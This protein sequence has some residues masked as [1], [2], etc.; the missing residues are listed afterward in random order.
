MALGPTPIPEVFVLWHPRCR[1]GEA[2]APRIHDWLR[3][4]NGQG[5]EVFYRSLAAPDAPEGGLPPAL[6]G[7][8]RGAEGS[9]GKPNVSNLQ[10]LLPLID[11]NLIVDPAWRYWLLELGKKNSG[12]PPRKILPVALDATAYNLPG[13]LR[14]LNFL[15]PS[16]LPMPAGAPF[17]GEAF[18]AV[19]RSLLRQ[20]TEA[21]CRV[22]LSRV[23]QQTPNSVALDEAA[24]K[25]TLFLSHA[26]VDGTVPAK[27]LRDHI[28]SQTQLAAFY[29]ENDIAYGSAFNRAIQGDVA[30]AETA[31]FIAVRSAEYARRAWCRRELSLFRRPRLVVPPV[32]GDGSPKPAE[33]WGMYPAIVVEA[34][35]A[36]KVHAWH[37]RVR[38]QPETRAVTSVRCTSCTLG[39][40]CPGASETLAKAMLE[41]HNSPRPAQLTSDWHRARTPKLAALLDASAG[42]RLPDEAMRTPELL[43]ELYSFLEQARIDLPGTL[44]TCLDAA[45]TR[46]LMTTRNDQVAVRLVREGLAAKNKLRRLPG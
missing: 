9:S 39:E 44:N 18:E 33:R 26:K 10:I 21:M 35:E 17:S 5:P 22:L 23:D 40:G 12:A 24:P 15:R 43:D 7:E 32:S 42:F 16:G 19:V 20:L 25:I 28:Y 1:L 6:P 41:P 11:E 14:E 29:D 45:Q 13:S 2:L 8:L 46:E 3:P 27:R 38:Q 34:I 36:G 37:P 30:A 4:G 31:G